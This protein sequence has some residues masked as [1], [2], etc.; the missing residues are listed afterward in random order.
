MAHEIET[1][2]YAGDI[3]WHDL[4]TGVP[5]NVTWEQALEVGGLAWEVEL[6]ELSLRTIPLIDSLG[7][8]SWRAVTRVTD[9]RVLG[10]VKEHYR[11]IQNRTA[12]SLFERVFGDQAVLHTAG[13]LKDGKVVWGL[14]EFPEPLEVVGEAH[15]RF[16]L[17]TTAHDGSGSLIATPV[18]TRVLCANTL[19]CALGERQ[20]LSLTVEHR[21]DT[22]RTVREAGG[23]LKRYLAMYQR[24]A[25]LADRL[26]ITRVGAHDEQQL[27]LHW[28][29]GDEAKYAALKER[30]QRVAHLARN[31]DGNLPHGGTAYGLL[32]GLTQYVDHETRASRS[33]STL[34]RFSYQTL[35]SGADLKERALTDLVAYAQA[36]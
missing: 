24:Y 10:V 22:D 19:R 6:R 14:A 28:F 21:G 1:M 4:G 36:A 3:P 5:R 9:S 12:F 25:K 2:M 23:V 32:Q 35:G 30:R 15:R 31:G 8:S 17:M 27:L 13:S 33:P 26:A 11:P 7:L 18:A 16:L 20:A 29:P 34:R